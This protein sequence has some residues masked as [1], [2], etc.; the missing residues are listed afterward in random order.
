[1]SSRSPRELSSRPE[2]GP[3]GLEARHRQT[4][5]TRT[6]VPAGRFRHR[7]QKLVPHRFE[8]NVIT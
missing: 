2:R 7:G 3:H 8:V 5:A 6:R 4:A 1:M